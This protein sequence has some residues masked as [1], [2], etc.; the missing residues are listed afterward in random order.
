MYLTA[1]VGE[2]GTGK[3]TIAKAFAKR[4]SHVLAFDHQHEYG[5]P[6]LMESDK[7]R[8]ALFVGKYTVED[9][10]RVSSLVN[11]YTIIAEE[12]TGLIDGRFFNSNNG[13]KLIQLVLSKRHSGHNNNWVFIFHTLDAIP[14]AL[15]GFIDYLYVFKTGDLERDVRSKFPQYLNDWKHQQTSNEKIKHPDGFQISKYNLYLR[16]NLAKDNTSYPVRFY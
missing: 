10:L 16:T 2:T 11:G 7:K 12:C 6:D 8:F 15:C 4:E 13:K 14:D 9:F 3:S 1:I 5:L